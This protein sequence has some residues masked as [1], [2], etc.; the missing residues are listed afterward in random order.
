MCSGP[1]SRTRCLVGGRPAAYDDPVVLV[2]EQ[3]RSMK[4]VV[5]GVTKWQCRELGG[6]ERKI[7]KSLVGEMPHGNA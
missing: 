7:R 3:V 2:G 4:P 5:A 6:T 1:A